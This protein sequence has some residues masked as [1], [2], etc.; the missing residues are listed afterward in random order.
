FRGH[1]DVVIALAPAALGA[2]ERIGEVRLKT[3][4]M[5]TLG[6]SLS[7]KGKA[8]EAKTVMKEAVQL[9]A[10]AFGEDDRRTASALSALANAYAMNGEL[11]PAIEA[12]TRALLAS[13]KSYG[14]EHPET[15]IVRNNLAAD[16]LYGLHPDRAAAE[17]T[18]VI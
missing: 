4:V 14:A 15:A 11:E 7:E 8:E 6:S 9:R 17:L 3:E 16:H 2:A 18:K 5:L 13:E 12:H 10:A 1:N